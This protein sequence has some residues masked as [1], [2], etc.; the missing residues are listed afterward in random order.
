M[1]KIRSASVAAAVFCIG[2]ALYFLGVFDFLE[3]K[4]YDNRTLLT[5]SALHT[6]DKICFVEVDQESI[7]WAKEKMGW[8]WPWPRSAYGDI[9]RYMNKGNAES[10]LFDILF[11]EP[12]VYGNKDDE[13]F[14]EA[15]SEYGNVVQTMFVNEE[16]KTVLFP[17][18]PIK[19]SARLISNITSAKDSDD[20]IRRTRL[21]FDYNGKNYSTLG[22][23]PYVISKSKDENISTE[24]ALEYLQKKLPVQKDGTLL[25]RYKKSLNDYLPYRAS[26]ILQSY[27]DEKKGKEPLIPSEN[28]AD[29]DVYVAYYAP[30][31]FDICS[32]PVSQVYPGVGVHI[33]TY[34]NILNN[35]FVKKIPMWLTILYLLA[36]CFMGVLIIEIAERQKSQARTTVFTIAGAAFGIV[37]IIAFSYVLFLYSV[38]IILVAPLFCFSFSFLADLFLNYLLEGRQKKFIKSAF[39]Q[40]LSPV[41]I[42]Q[43]ISNPNKLK[44][45]GEKREIS[46]YFSDVQGF[47]SISENLTPEKL[48]E[49]LNDYLSEMT[50]IILE[51]GGTIDKYEGDALI[52][53]WNAPT[54]EED[55]AKRAIEAA[56][57]CQQK[58]A[59]LRPMLEKLSGGKMYQRIGMNTGYAVV[60]NMG[61]H[62]RF[63]YTMM[64]DSVNLASRLEGLNKQFGT[65]TM[66]S[67]ETKEQAEKFGIN[68]K[69][70]ELAKVAV[71]GKKEAVTVYEPMEE[72]VFNQKKSEIEIFEKARVLFYDGKFSEALPL[73]ESKSENDPPCKFYAE[74]CKVLI[75]KPQSEFDGV[76]H[77]TEK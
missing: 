55:H 25:L 21:C 69:F 3:N 37:L 51:S 7:D 5:S 27:Y 70:R 6:S 57:K 68:L 16:D 1:K 35:N 47:T 67:K 32:A 10:V 56:M 33:T 11:T 31:L 34:D 18:E 39:S 28:F 65:Y 12:S 63:N 74:K 62:S 30:G 43:L 2:L 40:Y 50:D 36:S 14:A 24:D 61:S 38:W 26:D 77:T 59:E 75:G 13:N 4:T 42:D 72:D 66:C 54:S 8:G 23:A 19:N 58:L 20:V 22:T 49:I 60:G 52:A 46:I 9:V 76:W 17:V 71:V 53:F 73:F 44:L 41:V 48:T 64:G 15:C 45:G 29:A